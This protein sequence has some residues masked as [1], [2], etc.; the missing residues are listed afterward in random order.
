LCL[1]RFGHVF[2]KLDGLLGTNDVASGPA[3]CSHHHDVLFRLEAELVHV[4]IVL[5]LGP[6]EQ[7]LLAVWFDVREAEEL[8]LEVFPGG[9]GLDFNLILLALVLDDN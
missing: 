9:A 4:R 3:R 5:E 2:D 6:F 1:L 7:D 8:E